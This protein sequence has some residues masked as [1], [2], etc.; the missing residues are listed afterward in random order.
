MIVVLDVAAAGGDAGFTLSAGSTAAQER[1]INARLLQ[2]FEDALIAGDGDVPPRSRELHDKW[3]SARR[4]RKLLGVDIFVG[5]AR[6]TCRAQHPVDHRLG[7]AHIDMR[8]ERLVAED[9]LERHQL[10]LVLQIDVNALAVLRLKQLAIRAV[11]QRTHAVMELEVCS[12]GF[13]LAHH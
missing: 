13:E 10:P 12:R 11:L 3:L 2:R 6:E 1:R 9:L 4:C 7:T 8:A 5:P